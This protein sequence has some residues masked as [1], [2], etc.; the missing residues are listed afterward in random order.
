MHVLSMKR[1]KNA[2]RIRANFRSQRSLFSRTLLVE[3][4]TIARRAVGRAATEGGRLGLRGFALE[5]KGRRGPRAAAYLA[6]Q[7]REL[8]TH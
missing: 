6:S 1:R 2:I 4:D 7:R 3:G 5:R 8:T